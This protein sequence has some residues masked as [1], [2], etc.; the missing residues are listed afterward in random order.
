M[1]FSISDFLMTFG[2]S[3]LMGVIFLAVGMVVFIL[4]PDTV[5][6]WLFFGMTTLQ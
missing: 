1:A 4:K 2:S 5:V 6:S 3:L